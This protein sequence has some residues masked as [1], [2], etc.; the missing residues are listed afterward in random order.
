MVTS[1]GHGALEP[2]GRFEGE[3]RLADVRRGNRIGIRMNYHPAWRARVVSDA[4]PLIESD[5]QL[6]FKAPADGELTVT[7]EYPRPA[8]LL[9]VS[10][11]AGWRESG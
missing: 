2:V 7:L 9:L 3:V 10:A 4:L 6:S 11:I 8:L 1:Q 5:G